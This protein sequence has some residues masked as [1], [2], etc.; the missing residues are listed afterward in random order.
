MLKRLH[1]AIEFQQD[2]SLFLHSL[3]E[4][5]PRKVLY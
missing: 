5:A 3:S 2:E 1:L 4:S